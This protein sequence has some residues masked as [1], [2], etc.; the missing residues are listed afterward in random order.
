MTDSELKTVLY[1]EDDHAFILLVQRAL[2][3][4]KLDN[5]PKLRVFTTVEEAIVYLVGQPPYDDRASY[6]IPALVLTDLRLPGKS[7]IQLLK[8]IREQENLHNLP[9][10]MLTGSAIDADIEE[11]YELGVNFCLVKPNDVETLV[12]IVQALSIYWVPPPTRP[13]RPKGY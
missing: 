7:G 6:P 8:W 10:V 3:R 4:S 2:Q 11:A 13:L 1:V 5:L 9:V 12:S